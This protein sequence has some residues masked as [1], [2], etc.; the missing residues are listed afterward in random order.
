VYRKILLTHDGSE[1]ADVAVPHAIAVAKGSGAEMVVL[2]VID[3]VTQVIAQTTP[4]A[5]DPM[6]GGAMAAEIAEESVAAQRAGAEENLARLRRQIEAEGVKVTA[7]IGQG[8]AGEMIVDTVNDQGC[9]LVV[10]ATHGRSGI[11]RAVLGSVADHVVRHTQ[12][13]A[14]LI[15]RA[16]KK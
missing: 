15:V 6:P 4:A 11:F 10:I 3:S 12:G 7:L 2:Q 14:V 1:L 8:S 13:S 16:E 5:I 9:D